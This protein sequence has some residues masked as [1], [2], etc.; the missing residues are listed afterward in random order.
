MKTTKK[1]ELRE[2]AIKRLKKQLKPGKTVYTII[3]SVSSSGMSRK[4]SLAIA[5]KNEIQ[6]IDWEVSHALK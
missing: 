2:T 5:S 6:N 4:I 3:R 1:N